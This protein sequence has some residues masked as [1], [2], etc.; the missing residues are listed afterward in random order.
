MKN[1][2]LLAILLGSYGAFAENFIVRDAK[3]QNGISANLNLTVHHWGFGLGRINGNINISDPELFNGNPINFKM[4]YDQHYLSTGTHTLSNNT[5][6]GVIDI[7]VNLTLDSMITENGQKIRITI[8]YEDEVFYFE[9]NMLKNTH[10]FV[11]DQIPGT[12]WMAPSQPKNSNV[13]SFTSDKGC[14][15]CPVGIPRPSGT[16]ATGWRGH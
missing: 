2:V 9:Y 7:D 1:V 15:M 10:S 4:N 12:T 3:T 6:E 5:F 8:S 13:T 11:G 14:W 16:Q